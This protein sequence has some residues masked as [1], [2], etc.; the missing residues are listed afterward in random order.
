MQHKATTYCYKYTLAVG[1]NVQ[2]KI[3]LSKERWKL[4]QLVPESV[5]I[6]QRRGILN[7]VPD[8]VDLDD[9]LLW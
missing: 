4:R 5:E 3:G 6:I 1:Q 9:R 8:G 7:G 2:N